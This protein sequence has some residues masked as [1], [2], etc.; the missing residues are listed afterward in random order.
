MFK[1]SSVLDYKDDIMKR[2]HLLLMNF[3]GNEP[4]LFKHLCGLTVDQ[5]NLL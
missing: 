5:F 1:L 2:S 4:T 3:K